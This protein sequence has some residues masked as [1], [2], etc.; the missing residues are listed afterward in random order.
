M[1]TELLRFDIALGR[2]SMSV[3]FPVQHL[4]ED[5]AGESRFESF[6]IAL[7]ETRFAPPARP[8]LVSKL[9]PAKGF[10]AIRIPVGWVGELHR[11]PQRQ[12]LFCLAGALKVTASDGGVR[13]VDTGSIWQMEDVTGKGHWSEVS[14]SVPFDAVIIA[15]GYGGP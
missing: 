6:A 15:L 14:S 10:V 5:K 13:I 1:Q 12:I 2:R 4:V 11:S 9:R 8:F 3:E 7:D